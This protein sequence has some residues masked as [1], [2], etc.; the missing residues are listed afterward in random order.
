MADRLDKPKEY[1][2]HVDDI[3]FKTTETSL[4]GSEIK[5][6]AARD[7]QYQLFLEENEDD[8]DQAIQDTELVS[9]KNGLHFYTI[10]PATFGVK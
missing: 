2:V 10:P 6:L 3:I 1:V 8:L 5:A 9:L 7:F 4:T